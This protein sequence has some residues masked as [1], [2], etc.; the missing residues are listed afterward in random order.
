[1]KTYE[2]VSLIKAPSLVLFFVQIIS[3]VIIYL[4]DSLAMWEMTSISS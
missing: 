1:M 3:K 4:S 2:I